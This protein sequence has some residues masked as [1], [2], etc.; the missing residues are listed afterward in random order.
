MHIQS[1]FEETRTAVLHELIRRHPLT[2]FICNQT[3]E[4]VV[5]HLPLF[6]CT[7]DSALGVLK[8]HIPKENP[9]WQSFGA[10]AAVAVFQGPE[11]YVSPS[12]Y[13]SKQRH[14]KVVPT[15]NYVV[16]HARGRPTAIHD[17]DWLIEHLH[18]MTDQ[19][20]ASQPQPWKVSDA[21]EEFTTQM[22]SRL[23]GIEV[24]IASIVGKWK[25]SQNRLAE[26]QQ[27]VAQG[28]RSIGDDQALAMERLMI[29][30]S[31]AVDPAS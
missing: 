16:V 14:S 20:E 30:R 12:W 28:L 27:G 24:R 18:Q 8:G 25:V 23:V 17:A 2:T 11:S 4:I 6:L 5:N 10:G 13:P 29:D 7:Q 9:V 1:S 26:D 15:W 3:N 19:H 22:V 21:P 31:S